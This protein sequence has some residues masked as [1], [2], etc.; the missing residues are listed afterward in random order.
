MRAIR[1]IS[2]G[3]LLLLVTA[4]APQ[5]PGSA[6]L[7]IT[8]AATA[9]ATVQVK[10]TLPPT[11][12]P[13]ATLVPSPQPT[14]T[15]APT[16]G[17]TATLLTVGGQPVKFLAIAPDGLL[18]YS[19]L[20]DGI[21]RSEDGG[22]T[23]QRVSDQVLRGPLL[24]SQR[25]PHTLLAGAPL[26]CYRGDGDLLLRRSTD[27][28]ATWQRVENGDG[29]QPVATDA[30]DS[31]IIYGISCA[32]LYVSRDGGQTWQATASSQGLVISAIIPAGNGRPL[33]LGV[34]TSE[35]GTSHLVWFDEQGRVSQ[36][37]AQGLSFWGTG[38]L[39]TTEENLY[40]ATSTGVWRSADGAHWVLYTDGL[41]DVTLKSDPLQEPV[42]QEAFDRGFGL[43][44]LAVDPNSQGQRLVLGTIRGLYISNDGG[45]HW[46]PAP[47]AG[48]LAQLRINALAWDPQEK[49]VLYATTPQGVWRVVMR[50][51]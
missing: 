44:S 38:A 4:C 29:I 24:I 43:F 27:G 26:S 31:Q 23:W 28:G 25:D 30:G 12:S 42:P 46:Q 16:Q 18:R 49:G 22:R 47:E 5:V 21:A 41:G 11:A 33:L 51:S 1:W 48:A 2:A 15:P 7:V 39:A 9:T 37:L 35:G 50:N 19:V 6:P 45:E 20:A 14:A 3:L 13:T 17:A 10:P 32:G 40:V 8:P 34:L 36:D